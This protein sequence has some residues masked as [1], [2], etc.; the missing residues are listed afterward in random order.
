MEFWTKFIVVFLCIC[1]ISG[2]VYLPLH[3]LNNK[4]DYAN[5]KIDEA[6]MQVLDFIKRSVV[7][8]SA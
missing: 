7:G 6:N 5:K 8:V 4:V 2:V 1:I 3:Y